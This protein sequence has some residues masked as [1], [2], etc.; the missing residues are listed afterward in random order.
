MH[1]SSH[2]KRKAI[3]RLQRAALRSISIVCTAL[4]TVLESF[5]DCAL[6]ALPLGAFLHVRK[7]TCMCAYF[8]LQRVAA[9]KTKSLALR[10]HTCEAGH[11]FFNVYV[12]MCV[13]GFAHHHASDLHGHGFDNEMTTALAPCFACRY[14]NT[15]I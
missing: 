1:G 8:V 2:E 6:I 5:Q 3:C 10:I 13:Y 12:Y 7:W 11:S 4:F 15:P 9:C 14:A